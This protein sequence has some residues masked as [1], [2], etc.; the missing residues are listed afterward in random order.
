MR[1]LGL[2]PGST[3]DQ[4]GCRLIARQG[5]GRAPAS[6]TRHWEASHVIPAAEEIAQ[7][8]GAHPQPNVPPE[9]IARLLLIGY[10][11]VKDQ[12]RFRPDHHFY[13]MADE[14]VSVEDGTVRLGKL[15]DEL[16]K[17]AN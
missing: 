3:T 10:I 12:R 11:K 1:E 4:R 15:R 16:I 8:L 6:R 7:S 17:S 5:H 9:L 14:I 13:A 2:P